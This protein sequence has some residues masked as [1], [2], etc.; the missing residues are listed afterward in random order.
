MHRLRPSCETDEQQLIRELADESSSDE[1]AAG[2]VSGK[3]QSTV[4]IAHE[5]LLSA[6]PLLKGW[7]EQARGHHRPQPNFRG[8]IRWTDV[9]TNKPE[10]AGEEL[11]RRNAA[12]ANH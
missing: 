12:P 1:R 11:W 9:K 5:A 8:C 2:D 4:E 6:W 10:L 3:T 7:I